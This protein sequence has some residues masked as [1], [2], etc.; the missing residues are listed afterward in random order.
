MQE[1]LEIGVKYSLAAGEEADG[2]ASSSSPPPS[3]PSSFR[4]KSLVFNLSDER[5]AIR[6]YVKPRMLKRKQA[7]EHCIKERMESKES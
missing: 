1:P 7:G 3:S 4:R 5:K 2:A 6:G